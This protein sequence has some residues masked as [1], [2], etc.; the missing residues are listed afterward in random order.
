MTR[1]KVSTHCLG[2]SRR[3]EWVK[4]VKTDSDWPEQKSL[5]QWAKTG[6]IYIF[7]THKLKAARWQNNQH[8]RL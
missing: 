4:E 7:Y 6:P 2:D 5:K 3:Y 8:G 1:K